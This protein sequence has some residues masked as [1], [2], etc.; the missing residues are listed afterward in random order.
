MIEQQELVAKLM[1][2]GVLVTPEQLTQIQTGTLS[3]S[4]KQQLPQELLE[5]LTN[6]P[7][8]PP[9]NHPTTNP[10]NKKTHTPSV[11]VTFSY[12]KPAK[13]RTYDDFVAHWKHRFN[14]LTNLLRG[15]QELQ[16]VMSIS[17]LLT[18][19]NN[20]VTLIGMIS[21]K[22][23]T[24]NNNIILKLEDPTG[25]ITVIITQREPKLHE[26][27][28]NLVLD[29]VIGVTGGC[30]DKTVFADKILHPD[31][32]LGKELKKQQEEE[33]MI[34]IGDPQVGNKHFLTKE[35][36]LM[37]AWLNGKLGTDA[38]KSV[39]AKVKYAIIVGDLIE[40][41]G[42][43]PNQE[44][45]L[46]ILDVTKQYERF[47]ELASKIPK[48]I[49][50]VACP[51]NHDAGR[52]AEPQPPIYKDFGKS[53][54]ALP[55]MTV[56]SSP[57][58]VTIGKTPT[59]PGFDILIYHG[60]SLPYYADNIPAIMNAGGL[61]VIDKIMKFHLQRRHLAVTHK[62]NRYIPDAEEDPLI[63]KTIPDFYFTGHIHS[64]STGNYRNVTMI[65]AGAWTGITE[66][67]I[68]RGLEPEPARLPIINLKTREVTIMNF[69]QGEE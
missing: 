59:F 50:L 26:Q 13:K 25:E 36:K 7:Q 14:G 37:T 40:G 64:I 53:V 20:R 10:T 28:I 18:Q 4:L 9:N 27:A 69:Y 5:Q 41:V 65:N 21:E 1:D 60:Y 16:G 38:Q 22:T 30:K 67:Q 66:D 61:K 23:I 68:K 48:H 58:M 11:E 12:D 54:Y 35:W 56:I 39:A 15:R 55:N 46:E 34:V 2:S 24:K 47:S 8:Q 17:R 19:T 51:G 57:G 29:E 43:Y 32:P 62:S 33:Y 42:I 6:S 45:D 3:E 49:H 44:D 52:I 63:I 31:I